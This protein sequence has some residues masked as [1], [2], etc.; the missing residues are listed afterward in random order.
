MVPQPP[1]N[2]N[3]A[4]PGDL[5]GP[6]RT[7]HPRCPSG[8]GCHV[9][10]A[11]VPLM[12]SDKTG[13]P[14]ARPGVAPG[15][16]QGRPVSWHRSLR[17]PGG[18]CGGSGEGRSQGPAPGWQGCLLLPGSRTTALLLELQG[19]NE[20]RKLCPLPPGAVRTDVGPGCPASTRV[21]RSWENVSRLG[22]SP[23]RPRAAGLWA[24]DA[25]Q[26]CPASA[27]VG[28]GHI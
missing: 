14:V 8:S 7:P 6:P 3:G 22:S 28:R 16:Q 25:P 1:P 13:A 11:G 5:P 20:P 24:W 9:A 18:R 15:C 12:D 19:P 27:C 10:R 2:S 26:P 4:L 17:G 21:C 23:A